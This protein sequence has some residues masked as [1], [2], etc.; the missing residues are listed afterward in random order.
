VDLQSE[1]QQIDE[2]VEE[3]FRQID[4]KRAD[5]EEQ[6]RIF[7]QALDDNLA[8]KGI[9][10]REVKILRERIE[11]LKKDI[12][13]VEERRDELT[14]WQRFIKLDW[15]QIRPEKQKQEGE[16]SQQK[17]ELLQSERQL[18]AEYQNKKDKLNDEG[19]QYDT[20]MRQAGELVSQLKV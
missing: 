3:L 20:L 12:Q 19:K 14:E 1:Q 11:T 6:I 15:E 17:R 13:A 5:M 4:K 16:L 7:Q 9:D 18:K 10:P 8:K 2:K